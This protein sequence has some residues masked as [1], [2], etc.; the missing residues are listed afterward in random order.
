[1]KTKL[2]LKVVALS[3]AISASAQ[4]LIKHSSS[5]EVINDK[6]PSLVETIENIQFSNLNNTEKKILL[7]K[8]LNKFI[9]KNDLNKKI[10][11]SNIID[12]VSSRGNPG[13]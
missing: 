10:D 6:I 13:I 2:I 12:T 5:D 3:L 4:T 1:M 7:Q 11:I 9:I 8:E